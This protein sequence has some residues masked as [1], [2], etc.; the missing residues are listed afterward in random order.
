M[1]K[2]NTKRRNTKKN[3]TRRKKNQKGGFLQNT[4]FKIFG[5]EFGQQSGRQIY[6]NGQWREQKC[7]NIL[8]WPFCV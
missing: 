2:N 8:G 7:Y 6:E 5:L 3:I 4:S 1:N